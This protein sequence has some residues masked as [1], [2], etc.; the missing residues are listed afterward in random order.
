MFEVVVFG[1]SM[2]FKFF[3]TSGFPICFC[4]WFPFFITGNPRHLISEDCKKVVQICEDIGFRTRWSQVNSKGGVATV[5][6]ESTIPGRWSIAIG[7]WDD[8]DLSKGVNWSQF[9]ENMHLG[10]LL[11]G[12][13]N[14]ACVWK[15]H[16][17]FTYLLYDFSF[18]MGEDDSN[19]VLE[20]WAEGIYNLVLCYGNWLRDGAKASLMPQ[21]SRIVSEDR[22]VYTLSI[23]MPEHVS[24]LQVGAV[25]LFMPEDFSNRIFERL[26]LAAM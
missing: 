26:T 17:F 10:M 15:Q 19:A 1:C 24:L 13:G 16:D 6:C 9:I 5:I 3:V 18:G 14:V 11:L 22:Q 8:W 7:P 4:T 21:Q 23:P 20:F 25:T 2:L 12:N